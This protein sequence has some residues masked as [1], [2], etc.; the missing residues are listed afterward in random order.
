[1]QHMQSVSYVEV[2]G[3]IS[4]LDCGDPFIVLKTHQNIKLYTLSVYIFICQK[5]AKTDVRE[6]KKQT[7]KEIED[8]L[9]NIRRYLFHCK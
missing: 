2:M 3:Y 6:R 4:D 1:M 9:Y 8:D 7:T 5:Y